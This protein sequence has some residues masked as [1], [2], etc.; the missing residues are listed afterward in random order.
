MI[1][2]YLWYPNMNDIW[3]STMSEYPWCPNIRDVLISVMSEYPW[4]P[5]IH[6]VQISMMSKYP[7]YPNI[8]DIW[9]P[10]KQKK[11]SYLWEVSFSREV[12]F[13]RRSNF[14]KD[15]HDVHISAI[16]D[17]QPRLMRK[18]MMYADARTHGNT[19]W[20]APVD[21]TASLQ[22]KMR[23]C[24]PGTCS[25]NASNVNFGNTTLH[26]QCFKS[27]IFQAFQ[28]SQDIY[29]HLEYPWYPSMMSRY[30]WCPNIHDFWISMMS[31]YPWHP[32]IH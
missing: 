14:T 31:E 29:V 12:N 22:V 5:N 15:I 23:K 32:N 17:T 1:S 28:V 9:Y 16:Y 6:D 18:M 13:P 7:W 11:I 20:N 8:H 25:A 21:L 19:E 26:W 10:W 4:C 3:I 24:P 30:S 2:N 27:N